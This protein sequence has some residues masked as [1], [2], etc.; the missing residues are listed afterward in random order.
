MAL[1]GETRIRL[2]KR[3]GFIAVKA[4]VAI[5]AIGTLIWLIKLILNHFG[6]AF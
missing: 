2:K 3:K 5:V 1:C 6:I 4:L